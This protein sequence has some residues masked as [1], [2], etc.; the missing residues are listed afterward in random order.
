[1]LFLNLNYSG[2]FQTPMEKRGVLCFPLVNSMKCPHPPQSGGIKIPP[3][4]V[5]YFIFNTYT[6]K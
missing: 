3:I 1:M 6:H 5:S 4:H 2:K